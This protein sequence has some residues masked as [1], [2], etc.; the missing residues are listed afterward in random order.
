M[1]Y[2]M[3]R[4]DSFVNVCINN[5]VFNVL[6][7]VLK[8]LFLFAYTHLFAVLYDIKYSFLMLKP[9]T[10]LHGIKYF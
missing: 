10:R 7:I 1:C 3:P 5:N 4:F 6:Q 8:Q 9:L 2:L